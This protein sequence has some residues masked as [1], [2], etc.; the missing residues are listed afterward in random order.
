MKLL[1]FIFIIP[2]LLL[3]QDHSTFDTVK[4]NKFI[5]PTNLITSF[6]GMRL[7]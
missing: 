2:T 6:M 3:G 5:T 4:V 7:K 1:L